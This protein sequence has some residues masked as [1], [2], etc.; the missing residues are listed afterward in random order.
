M[1]NQPVR[2]KKECNMNRIKI[3]IVMISLLASGLC[4]AQEDM[5]RVWFEEGNAAYNEGKYEQALE[6]YS[7]IVDFGMESPELYYNMGNV[8]YKMRSY[9]MSILYYE[10]ALKLDP[11]N[12][13]IRTNLEIANL[14]VVDKIDKIPESFI[15]RWWNGLKSLCSADGWAWVSISAFALTL[16]CLYLFLMSRRTGWRKAGFF[17]GLLML[18]ALGLSVAFAIG[19]QRDLVRQGEAIIITPTVTVMSSP[20][21]SSVD[22][23]VLHEGTKV[24]ILDSAKEWKKVKIADGSVGWLPAD[25]MIAF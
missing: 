5:T 22:L 7:H 2:I 6:R 16:L 15:V 18:L 19:K 20:S 12:E 3:V 14:A 11:G 17:A 4:M 24:S 21:E 10:K 23:F 13:D 25:D 8:Y 1:L 9:P